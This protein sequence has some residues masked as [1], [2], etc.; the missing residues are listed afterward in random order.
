MKS[1]RGLLAG[2]L[3]LGLVALP[4][5]LSAQTPAP[6]VIRQNMPI[7]ALQNGHFQESLSIAEAK[8]QGDFGIGAMSSLDG[9]IINVGG[10]I[11]QF[12][13]DG[14]VRVPANQ[15]RLSFSAMTLFRP[16]S[17]PIPLPAG[18]TFACLG[19]ML[20]PI[21][22]TLNTFYAIRIQ[23]T[24]SSATART[25][26]RQ[27]EP[28][29]PLCRVTPAV[30][31]FTNVSG[32]MVGYRSPGSPRYLENVALA[33]Y[34]LHFLN[35]PRNGGGHVLDF[36]VTNATVEIVPLRTLLLDFPN[37]RAFNTMDLSEPIT[38]SPPAPEPPTPV[39][40]PLPKK[41]GE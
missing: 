5:A 41:A 28:F 30:F 40:P 7:V 38:C 39:C 3:F 9:E 6:N 8:I 36:T 1:S 17:S 4:Y 24:F 19:P 12:K 29:P 16:S 21:L 14:T 27:Q 13:S 35:S 31:P 23:G 10:Q 32:T 26:P 2:S 18:T 34:H 20:D 33:N 22:P 25:F 37:D 15:E 11:Y